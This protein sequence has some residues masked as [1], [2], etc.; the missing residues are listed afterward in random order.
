VLMATM[1]AALGLFIIP[2]RR[3]AA[4]ADLNEKVTALRQQLIGSLRSQFERE[5]E[6]SLQHINEAISPYTR[7]VRAERAKLLEMQSGL[8]NIQSV[9]EQLK[10]RIEDS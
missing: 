5:I 8:E 1:I 2:A 3:R 7:F 6:R 4:K 10:Q 9:L